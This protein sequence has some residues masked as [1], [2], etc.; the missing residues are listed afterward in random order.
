MLKGLSF[1]SLSFTEPIDMSKVKNLLAHVPTALQGARVVRKKMRGLTEA[2]ARR[3]NN[4]VF[5]IGKRGSPKANQA[6]SLK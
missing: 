3:R 1:F 5:K 2:K 4:K 6:G